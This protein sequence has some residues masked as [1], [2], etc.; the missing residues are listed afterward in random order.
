MPKRQQPD[1]P[2]TQATVASY[3]AVTELTLARWTKEGRFPPPRRNP[4]G[5]YAI[6]PDE[7]LAWLRSRY[8]GRPGP[9]DPPRPVL[10][11]AGRVT[12]PLATARDIQRLLRITS[13]QLR[14]LVDSGQAGAY[15]LTGTTLRYDPTDPALR[16]TRRQ[17]A[18]VRREPR[19]EPVATL[20]DALAEGPLDP[21]NGEDL[22]L[23]G[24]AA[25]HA[26]G[27]AHIRWRSV[28][29]LDPESIGLAYE[30]ATLS[31]TYVAG[32]TGSVVATTLRLPTPAKGDRPLAVTWQGDDSHLSLDALR[33][34]GPFGIA[35][36][37]AISAKPAW[38]Q[39]LQSEGLA[40]VVVAPS[41]T[42]TT[43]T[44]PLGLRTGY[45]PNRKH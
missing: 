7:L 19:R 2:L 15:D 42:R 12:N 45:P 22:D 9:P 4:D 27:L 28:I 31:G 20:L 17:R 18:R 44:R 43:P 23:A 38:T 26:L 41:F 1:Q 10:D 6:D 32:I 14:W 37:L 13:T 11:S 21:N 36:V 16:P 39:A 25:I 3:L 30:I 24:A 5:S 8:I 34:H 35:T 40:V 29:P 33:H